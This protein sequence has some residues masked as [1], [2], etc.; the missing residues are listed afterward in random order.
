MRYNDSTVRIMKSS[1]SSFLSMSLDFGVVV[2]AIGVVVVRLESSARVQRLQMRLAVDGDRRA[3][4]FGEAVRARTAAVRSTIERVEEGEKEQRVELR[5]DE[6]ADRKGA[7]LHEE[8]AQAVQDD[9]RELHH[10]NGGQMALPPQVL[11][12]LRSECGQSVVGVHERVH[13]RVEQRKQR[14]VA[15]R[16]ELESDPHRNRNDAV[17]NDMQEA[18]LRVLFAQYE[19]DGVEK[20]D[21]FRDEK[22]VTNLN[23]SHWFVRQTV[24]ACACVCDESGRKEKETKRKDKNKLISHLKSS[25]LGFGWQ[26]KS[27]GEDVSSDHGPHDGQARICQDEEEEEMSCENSEV[28]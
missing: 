5:K 4:G 25:G 7:V 12:H 22:D 6:K 23:H 19:E 17:M 1:K 14:V 27:E 9:D 28:S 16:R 11:A 3:A 26:T 10:L 21:E 24:S 13:G 18:D 15:A 2:V 20:F 8:G